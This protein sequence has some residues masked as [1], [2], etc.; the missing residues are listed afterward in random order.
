[1]LKS[2]LSKGKELH[3]TLLFYGII[4][5][6]DTRFMT[7]ISDRKSTDVN[8]TR[9]ETK[10]LAFTSSISRKIVEEGRRKT[11]L[12]QGKDSPLLKL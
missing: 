7:L 6:L 3:Q 5:V 10:G 8:S 2:Y 12:I 9:R 1:M 4:V 11:R